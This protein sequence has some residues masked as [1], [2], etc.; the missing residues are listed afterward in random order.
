MEIKFDT[1][2]GLLSA[3]KDH[4]PG[5][6]NGNMITQHSLMIRD[7]SQNGFTAILSN[8]ESYINLWNGA[9]MLSNRYQPID[10]SILSLAMAKQDYGDTKDKGLYRFER[11]EPVESDLRVFNY[12]IK[13][14]GPS[15]DIVTKAKSEGWSFN[16]PLIASYIPKSTKGILNKAEDSLI[17]VSES[18]VMPIAFKK[19]EDWVKK[20]NK[21]FDY[22]VLRLKEYEGKNTDI[23]IDT[24]F[25]IEN[26]WIANAVEEP[27]SKL[28]LTD[29]KSINLSVNSRD[30]VTIL[31]EVKNS[32]VPSRFGKSRFYDAIKILAPIVG[33]TAITTFSVFYFK[34]LKNNNKKGKAAK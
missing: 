7:N 9:V 10:A 27:V 6:Y 33:I 24:I 22:Y 26:A 30:T 3:D 28:N 1:P 11:L 19:S 29:N 18:N 23:E 16:V 15:D 34:S 32:S 17:K 5:A 2:S 12:A 31:L 25:N 13:T 21:N 20:P 8:K 14:E 4:M